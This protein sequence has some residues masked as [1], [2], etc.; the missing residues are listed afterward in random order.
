MSEEHLPPAVATPVD[1][2]G[3]APAVAGEALQTVAWPLCWAGRGAP[4]GGAGQGPRAGGVRA[5]QGGARPERPARWVAPL[6]ALGPR[7]GGPH[8]WGTG[9]PEHRTLAAC[10]MAMGW[11]SSL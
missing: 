2:V 1:S 9:C 3:A 7:Q 4:M 10:L 5:L 6:P 8:P 11:G